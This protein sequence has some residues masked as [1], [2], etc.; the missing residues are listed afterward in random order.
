[1]EISES[2]RSPS[3]L[4]PAPTPLAPGPRALALLTLY[5]NAISHLLKTCSLPNFSACFPTPSERVPAA[6]KMLH[7]QF[8]AKLG[9]QLEGCFEALCEERGVVGRLNELDS[10]VGDARGRRDAGGAVEG[11]A[12][13][14]LPPQHLF[15]SHLAPQL[16]H[17]S[18]E[19]KTRQGEVQAEN[20]DVLARV[21]GQRREIA[22]LMAGLERKVQ[23]LD[24]SVRALRPEE[25]EG[26]REEVRGVDV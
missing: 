18:A 4:P 8:I 22:A 26:L 25:I 16:R 15:L 10:L 17:Y 12:A 7:E 13:H 6:M 3:P 24:E 9:E 2:A 21:Q 19:I 14:T 1:M 20:A 11:V 5:S 23:D